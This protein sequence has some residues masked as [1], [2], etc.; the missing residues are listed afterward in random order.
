[1]EM[2]RRFIETEAGRTKLIIATYLL[3]KITCVLF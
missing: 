2:M 1:M 3:R